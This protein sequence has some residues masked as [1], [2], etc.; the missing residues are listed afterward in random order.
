MRDEWEGLRVDEWVEEENWS[1]LSAK[2]VS[3]V[4]KLGLGL[5]GTVENAFFKS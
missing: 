3:L 4:F 2:E 1:A 5:F